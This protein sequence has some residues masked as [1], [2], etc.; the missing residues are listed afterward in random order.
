MTKAPD[1]P[2]KD[3]ARRGAAEQP[4]IKPTRSKAHRPEHP[5]TDPALEKF[6]VSGAMPA[7]GDAFATATGGVFEPPP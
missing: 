1:K 3:P 2:K 6:T 7:I 4:R 5:P